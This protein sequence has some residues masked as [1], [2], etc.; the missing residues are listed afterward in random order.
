[1]KKSYDYIDSSYSPAKD[2]E[3]FFQ[4]IGIIYEKSREEVWAALDERLTEKPASGIVIFNS[5]RL[6]FGIAAAILL[7]AGIFSLLRFYTTPISCPAGQHLSYTLPDGSTI[8]M[9]ADSRMTF[10]PLWWQFARKLNFEGE[11]YFEVQK[12]KKFEVVSDFGRTVVLGT[13]FNIYSRESEY[14]VTCF[15]GKVKVISFTSD[16]AVLSPEYEARVDS[17]GNIIVWKDQNAGV[18]NSW[19][20]NMFVFTAR[21]LIQV[22]NEIGR[23]YDVTIMFKTKLDYSY[24]GYFSKDRPV[25]EVLTLVCKPFG[26]TFARIS[27][28]EYDIYQN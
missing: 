4:N 20:N 16:E 3:V 14:K 13:S 25:E 21:P 9:N 6:A 22:F 28:K 11:G 5:Y 27:E 19:I 1:M 8:E 10:N 18:S 15:T 23:Q 7:L 12:G 2:P 24:T 17:D 26:L